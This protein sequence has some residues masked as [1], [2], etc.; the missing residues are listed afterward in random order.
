MGELKPISAHVRHRLIDV[1]T[2]PEFLAVARPHFPARDHWMSVDDASL[3]RKILSQVCVVGNTTPW[4]NLAASGAPE[5]DLSFSSLTARS[6]SSQLTTI[7]RCLREYGVRYVTKKASTCRKSQALASNLKKLR[8][9]PGGAK[10]YLGGL[11]KLPDDRNRVYQVK[12]D[13]AYI[14]NKGARDLLIDLDLGRSL[15]A[16][17]VRVLNVLGAAGMEVPADVQADEAQYEELQ[18]ALVKD[19]CEPASLTG[20]EFDRVLFRNYDAIIAYLRTGKVSV[21]T[22]Q[23]Q[24]TAIDVARREGIAEGKRGT[25]YRLLTRAGIAFSDDDRGRL[26]ACADVAALDRWC[27]NVLGAKTIGEVLS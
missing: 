2:R 8:E 12:R 27:E 10:A 11:S 21:R 25:L 24:R 7:H 5:A 20:A 26:E 14:K 13:W 16:F 19:V 6:Q 17:D 1:A 15:I 9:L 22:E 23:E 18:K 3:W 4:D